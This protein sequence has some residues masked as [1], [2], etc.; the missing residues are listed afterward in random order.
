MCLSLTPRRVGSTLPALAHALVLAVALASIPGVIPCLRAQSSPAKPTEN[1]QVQI[2]PTLKVEVRAVLLDVAVTNKKGE[3][4]AGLPEKDFEVLEDGVP[5]TV[6][7]FAEH[8]DEASAQKES[9]QLPP[10]VYSSSQTIKTS[11]SVNVLLLD[12]LNTQPPDQAYVRD[13]VI[14]YLRT[15]PQGTRLAI[16]QLGNELRIV[17][18][19]TTESSVLLARLH[20]QKAGAIPKSVG[21]LA[22]E[23]RKA[24]EQELVDLM[25]KSDAAPVA[26][27]AVR[28]SM[29]ANESKQTGDR[30]KLTMQGLL[31]LERYLSAIP[32]R[33]NVF[34]FSGSFPISVFPGAGLGTNFEGDLQQTARQFGPDRI[35][36]YPIAAEGVTAASAFDPS[37]GLESRMRVRPPDPTQSNG[38]GERQIT[39]ETLAKES[40]GEAFYNPNNLDRD[41]KRA[42][43]DAAHYYTLTYSPANPR[44]DGKFRNIQVKVAGGNYKL[45]YRRGYFAESPR[46]PDTVTQAQ[47][48]D[49]L[50]GLMR[51]GMPDFDQL[52]YQVRVTPA[53]PQP[54]LGA[55]RAGVNS[56]LKEPLTRYS[57]DFLIPMKSL[58]LDSAADG[59][60]HAFIELMLVAYAQNGTP[61]NLVMGKEEVK[62]PEKLYESSQNVQIHA[63]QEIDVPAGNLFLR[64]GLYEQTSGNLGTVGVPL[65]SAPSV[66]GPKD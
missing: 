55:P 16:F 1:G 46:S 32:G 50:L 47:E 15:V 28:D 39:M 9:E 3:P 8:A 21:L 40:G 17:Q 38:N 66:N 5:Q 19:F 37:Q 41:L 56:D 59:I 20:D 2:E 51:F 57:V 6:S 60:R 10:N 25:V 31:E 53:Q 42:L 64:A 34:W 52:A 63:R 62:L 48:N 23:T 65:N 4:V 35:A 33:K 12:W 58:K 14:K 18:G 45:A 29:A 24:S 26:V 36:I 54:A 49:R 11:D 22:S 44:M 7:F 61:L 27:S 30:V 13:Q 43:S